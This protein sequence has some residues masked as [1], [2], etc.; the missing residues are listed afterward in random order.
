MSAAQL[1]ARSAAVS[2]KL[3][4]SAAA[5]DGAVNKTINKTE[6]PRNMGSSDTMRSRM[7]KTHEGWSCDFSVAKSFA[8][9]FAKSSVRRGGA[10]QDQVV[11]KDVEVAL[12]EVDVGKPD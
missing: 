3:V 10:C 5:S 1:L 7:V 6:L 2:A 9:S 8:K 12:L 11:A 4:V